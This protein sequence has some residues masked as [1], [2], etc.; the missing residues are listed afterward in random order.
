MVCLIST[1]SWRLAFYATDSMTAVRLRTLSVACESASTSILWGTCSDV[2]PVVAAGTLAGIM[3]PAGALVGIIAPAETSH[4]NC[5]GRCREAL[6]VRGC[7][8]ALAAL[9]L[10][11]VVR[12]FNPLPSQEEALKMIPLHLGPT[13]RIAVMPLPLRDDI[14]GAQNLTTA[15]ELTDS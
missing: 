6:L 14:R 11:F 1:W 15:P 9:S 3:N 12:H 8:V 4:R 5:H 10:R 2:A 7:M 13:R